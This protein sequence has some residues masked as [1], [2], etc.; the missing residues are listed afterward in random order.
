[1]GLNLV[2]INASGVFDI[3]AL[4]R[5]F[6]ILKQ[7]KYNVVV[8]HHNCMGTIGV[9]LAVLARVPSV[10]KVEMSD[11]RRKPLLVRVFSAFAYLF[12]DKLVCISKSTE[13]SLTWFERLI[14]RGKRVVIYNGLDLKEVSNHES[15][16]VATKKKLN[17]NED[18]IIILNVGRLH[19]IKNQKLIIQAFARLIKQSNKIHLIIA[20]IGPEEENLKTLAEQLGVLS[21]IRFVGF[22]SRQEVYDLF[23]IADIFI[24]ASYSEGFSEALLQAMAFEKPI[25]ATDIPSFREALIDKVS[26]ILVTPEAGHLAKAI[27][28]IIDNQEVKNKISRN[29]RKRIEKHYNIKSIIHAYENIFS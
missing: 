8:A 1:M 16:P 21:R 24:M 5:L 26:G 20:G 15:D 2:C 9:L 7:E 6:R 12:L 17:I 18:D 23:V 29:A 4:V 27:Q 19:N 11:V 22:I 14:T 3:P 25:V 28:Y 13:N 10:I